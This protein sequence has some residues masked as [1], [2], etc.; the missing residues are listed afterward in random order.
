MVLITANT[1]VSWLATVIFTVATCHFALLSNTA[2][3]RGESRGDGASGCYQTEDS[4][5]KMICENITS[6]Q[7][8]ALPPGVSIVEFRRLDT[9]KLD[10]ASFD[11]SWSRLSR[12]IISG[13]T[14]GMIGK[15]VAI[16]FV[17]LVLSFSG[18]VSLRGRILRFKNED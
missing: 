17:F 6:T 16:L 12:M 5:Q 2:V 7:G 18:R 1:A 11:D 4:P 9:D 3:L 15:R 8:M 10:T 13:S 14:I